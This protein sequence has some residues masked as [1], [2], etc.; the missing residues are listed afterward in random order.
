MGS[1]FGSEQNI[2]K[3]QDVTV[4]TNLYPHFT[5]PPSILNI[6]FA[7]D[8][9]DHIFKVVFFVGP[10]EIYHLD[11]SESCVMSYSNRNVKDIYIW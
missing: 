3:Y 11:V 1:D 4:Q 5:N 7:T 9:I 8:K 2:Y 6:D 10:P